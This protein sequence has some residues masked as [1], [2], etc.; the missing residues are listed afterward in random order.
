MA[1]RGHFS[2]RHV[3]KPLRGLKNRCN[4]EAE[5]VDFVRGLERPC[6]HVLL[7]P[8]QHYTFNFWPSLLGG[9]PRA[10]LLEHRLYRNHRETGHPDLT[11]G[12]F[13]QNVDAGMQ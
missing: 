2:E 10:H 1:F 5:N 8:Y 3:H 12:C 6:Y 13:F 7:L 11:H 4:A 9:S